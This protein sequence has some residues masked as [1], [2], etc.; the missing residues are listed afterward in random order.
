MNGTVVSTKSTPKDVFLYL[1]LMLTLYVGLSSLTAILFQY[2]DMWVGEIGSGYYGLDTLRW[3]VAVQTV[4]FPTFVVV[5]WLI[6]KDLFRNAQNEELKVRKWFLYLTL[7]LAVAITLGDLIS[8]LYHFLDGDFATQF[9]LK[10]LTVLVLGLLVCNYYLLDL[11]GKLLGKAKLFASAAS[12]VV[13]ASV[14]TGFYLVGTP[15]YQRNRKADEKTVYNLQALER[16]VIRYKTEKETLP[17]SL[18][19]LK[20]T[21]FSYVLED[22]ETNKAYEYRVVSPTQFELCANFKMATSKD[23]RLKG[24]GF[25][26]QSGRSC[27]TKTANDK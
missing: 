10:S 9:L 4:V 7:F 8:L 27:F 25:D 6:R 2:I 19:V 20:E 22:T 11:K 16:D 21:S 18:E 13:L 23:D 15:V 14:G 24:Y 26:H 17:P 3:L 5:S 12:V 1:G